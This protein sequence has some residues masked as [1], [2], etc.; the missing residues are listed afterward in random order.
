MNKYLKREFEALAKRRAKRE[1]KLNTLVRELQL[2]KERLQS[3]LTQNVGRFESQLQFSV[4]HHGE[5][6][7]GLEA[8]SC[9][10]VVMVEYAQ[11]KYF[12]QHLKTALSQWFSGARIVVLPVKPT[13]V[14]EA[15]A[16]YQ[17]QYEATG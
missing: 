7:A 3:M 14:E 11:D 9:D 6:G 10:I 5:V 8:Y 16:E 17:V 1:G 4:V 2:E 15:P 13:P 12:T